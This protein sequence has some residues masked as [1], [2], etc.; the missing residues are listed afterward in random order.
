MNDLSP[1]P[2]AND[3][4][5]LIKGTVSSNL[6]LFDSGTTSREEGSLPATKSIFVERLIAIGDSVIHHVDQPVDVPR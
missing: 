2:P 1:R 5:W 6:D 3:L 4:H